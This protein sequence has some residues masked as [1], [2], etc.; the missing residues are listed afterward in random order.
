MT[1]SGQ[2]LERKIK[3]ILDD[4]KQ[5]TFLWKDRKYKLLDWSKPMGQITGEVKTDFFL[6]LEELDSKRI[7]IIKISGKQRNMS[8]VQNKLTAMW[9]ETIY[10]KNWQ[11]HT[12]N[13]IRKVVLKDGFKKDELVNFKT[14]NIILGFRHEMM[15]EPNS[16]RERSSKT[17]PEIYPAVFWGEGFPKE[18]KDAKLK[19]LSFS[20]KQKLEE[21]NLTYKTDSNI[22]KNSGVPDY[23][24]KIDNEEISDINDILDNLSD[25]KQFA[26]NYKDELIDAYFAQNYRTRWTAEC[27][28]C[29][30]SYRTIWENE[31][32]NEKITNIS[33]YT[34]KC[35]NCSKM[36]RKNSN[37]EPIQGR[38][39]SMVVPIKW[40]VVNGK[41]DGVPVLNIPHEK[42]ASDVLIQLRNC[43]MELGTPDDNNF[44]IEM[45][46]DNIT[47]RT[48]KKLNKDELIKLL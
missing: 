48:V 20:T 16:G 28:H 38:H 42:D 9:N 14:G 41:L 13:Q 22:V 37:S 33:K 1:D 26:K 43:L 27:K 4:T 34:T 19:N 17:K 2:R 15:Y 6:V 40:S 8:A 47:E 10:G 11:Q 30:H 35:P 25:I 24:I 39:R 44:K 5:R 31:I 3:Y 36:G 46:Q 23:I 12:L 7:Q 29:N 45:L 18:Y 21:N 32:S